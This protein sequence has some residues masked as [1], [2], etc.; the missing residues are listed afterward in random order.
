M[1]GHEHFDLCFFRGAVDEHLIVG[2]S[3]LVEV[4]KLCAFG[5]QSLL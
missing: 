4:D 5:S 2:D 1:I 3:L